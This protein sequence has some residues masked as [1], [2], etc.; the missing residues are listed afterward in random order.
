[1]LCKLAI[2]EVCIK[3]IGC[4]QFL[5]YVIYRVI[6]TTRTEAVHDYSRCDDEMFL[7]SL[8]LIHI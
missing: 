5:N 1:M 3:S 8:S 6:D 4:K 7:Y 2:V